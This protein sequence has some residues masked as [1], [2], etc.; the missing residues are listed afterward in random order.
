[1]PTRATHVIYFK[2][3]ERRIMKMEDGDFLKQF[4]AGARKAAD[5]DEDVDWWNLPGSTRK[6]INRECRKEADIYPELRWELD[7]G[8]SDK[9]VR[10]GKN[11][12][13]NYP[14]IHYKR[15]DPIPSEMDAK[16]QEIR[17]LLRRLYAEKDIVKLK[18]KAIAEMQESNYS[19]LKDIRKLA[20]RV[21][22]SC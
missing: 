13:F 17:D 20:M 18:D 22:E 16:N 9:E 21:I 1:M 14:G 2:L 4:Y 19:L 5:D 6:A 3:N 15:V 7:D 11:L 12:S 8:I 10:L